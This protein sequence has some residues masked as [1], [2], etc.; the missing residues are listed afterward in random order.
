MNF[1]KTIVYNTIRLLSAISDANV[2]TD[3]T[4][5]SGA[6]CTSSANLTIQADPLLKNGGTANGLIFTLEQLQREFGIHLSADASGSAIGSSI[7]GSA[8]ISGGDC[9][10][11][12]IT[13][14]MLSGLSNANTNP[15]AA[16]QTPADLSN[17]S[18]K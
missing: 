17:R 3:G 2:L 6:S 7:A 5:S 1:F 18:R 15:P 4:N 16:H 13:I 11:Q 8:R 14:P 10:S 9:I 12:Y